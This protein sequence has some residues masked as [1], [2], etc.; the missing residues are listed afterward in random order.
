MVTAY[1]RDIG[2]PCP[3]CKS[4]PTLNAVQS[5]DGIRYEYQLECKKCG[6][7]TKFYIPHI[8]AVDEWNML[9]FQIMRKKY[10][11][12]YGL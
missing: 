1:N 5:G 6:I 2:K 12:K 4:D 8:D 10:V 11:R 9:V 7:K 3:K